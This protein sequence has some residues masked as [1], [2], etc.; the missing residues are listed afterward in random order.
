MHIEF[1]WKTFDELTTD[2]LYKIIHLRQKVFIVEQN[3]PYIDADYADQKANHLLV[4]EGKNLIGYLRAFEPGYKYSESSIG[5]IIID[6]DYRKKGLG[7]RITRAGISY[8]LEKF[9]NNNITIS[10]QYRLLS[11]YNKLGFLERGSVYLEDDIDHIEM[12]LECFK[13]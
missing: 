12:C 7:E 4:F 1:K 8:L 5:R 2:E 3:C 11:F 13:K 6:L 10:A 9:P